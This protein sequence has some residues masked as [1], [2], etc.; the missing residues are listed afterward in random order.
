MIEAINN[1]WDDPR[2][3][4]ITITNAAAWKDGYDTARAAYDKVFAEHRAA[5]VAL[6]GMQYS[7]ERW[8]LRAD[9]LD[10]LDGADG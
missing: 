7:W 9:V 8:V 5:I 3:S 1:S 10:I 6:P 2:K 4:N